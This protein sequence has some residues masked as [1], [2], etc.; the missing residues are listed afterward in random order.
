MSAGKMQAIEKVRR[1]TN[2]KCTITE[3]KPTGFAWGR[4][5]HEQQKCKLSQR[6]LL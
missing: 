3:A 1:N 6:L 2:G 5:E 4:F